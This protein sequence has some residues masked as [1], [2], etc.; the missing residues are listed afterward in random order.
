MTQ[1]LQYGHRHTLHPS[2]TLPQQIFTREQLVP[3]IHSIHTEQLKITIGMTY[4]T[5]LKNF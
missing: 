2:A 4:K 5:K 1:K 3:N